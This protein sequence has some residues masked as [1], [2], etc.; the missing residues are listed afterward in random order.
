MGQIWV[1]KYGM[2]Y[3]STWTKISSLCRQNPSMGGDMSLN[4]S[5]RPIPLLFTERFTGPYP[6]WCWNIYQHL[7]SLPVFQSY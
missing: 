1:L 3:Y 4:K 6:P 5:T 7:Q 2:A